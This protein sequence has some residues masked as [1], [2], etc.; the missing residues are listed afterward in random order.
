M[1]MTLPGAYKDHRQGDT[2]QPRQEHDDGFQREPILS[3][4]QQQDHTDQEG[5]RIRERGRLMMVSHV[6]HRKLYALCSACPLKYPRYAGTSG[7]TQ[8]ETNDSRPARIAV[9]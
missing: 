6:S 5:R 9:A 3:K 7:S 2:G 4:G 8:G 1:A